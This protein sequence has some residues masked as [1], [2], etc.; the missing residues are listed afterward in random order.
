MKITPQD[1]IDKEFRVKFR[2]FDMAEVDAFL[3]E[4]AE[5]F[6][7]LAEENTL[8]NEKILTLEQELETGG[9]TGLQGQ[10]ELPAE[11][12]SFLEDLKQDTT[13]IGAELTTLKQDRQIFDSLEKNIKD[14]LSSLQELAAAGKSQEKFDFPAEF[15]TAMEGVKQDSAAVASELAAL[16]QERQDLNAIKTNFEEIAASARKAASITASGE[17]QD[18]ISAGLGKT[19]ENVKEKAESIEAELASMKDGLGS[20]PGMRD[21]I[22]NEVRER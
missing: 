3:E 19:L 8:L 7:R 22:K 9:L 14:A 2:G 15:V 6:F 5:N 1:I 21:E 13:A 4:V 12:G 18:E 11:L 20:L 10:L 16:K 17:N